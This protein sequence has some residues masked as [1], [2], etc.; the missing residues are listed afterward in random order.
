M[1]EWG[2]LGRWGA[3]RGMFVSGA[4]GKITPVRFRAKQLNQVP[5][6]G[7]DVNNTSI[8]TWLKCDKGL[9]DTRLLCWAAG[10][11]SVISQRAATLLTG[12]APFFRFW[13]IR[14]S[15]WG[16][17]QR[18]CHSVHSTTNDPHKLGPSTGDHAPLWW[19]F[20]TNWI[21]A[22]TFK[23]NLVGNLNCSWRDLRKKFDNSGSTGRILMNQKV[24]GRA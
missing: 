7:L 21:D 13:K 18:S 14:K 22:D 20:R 11:K 4:N 5:P 2:V 16:G 8:S 17:R 12:G 24:L 19:H 3:E 1:N 23:W 15:G 10:R 9:L 6:V